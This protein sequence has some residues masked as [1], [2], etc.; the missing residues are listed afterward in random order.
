[1]RPR[2][3]ALLLAV[4]A[5]GTPVWTPPARAQAAAPFEIVPRSSAERPSHRLAWVTA[6]VGAGLVAGSFPLAAEADRRYAVYLT[7]TDVA[8]IEDRYHATTRMDRIASGALLTGEALLA[9][10]VWLRFLRPP[11][12]D[13]RV[14]FELEPAR[15]AVSLRF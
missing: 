15:C 2:L 3:A 7:E 1:M 10:A 4:W 12:E 14:T 6:L 13:D 5:S 11:R 9:T 8:R